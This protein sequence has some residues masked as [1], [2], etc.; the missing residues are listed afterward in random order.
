MV[1]EQLLLRL[2]LDR[3]SDA[4]AMLRTEEQRPEDEEIE[5]ALEQGDGLVV[6]FPNRHAV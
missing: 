6:T 1:D 4:L 5:R 3:A 2:L